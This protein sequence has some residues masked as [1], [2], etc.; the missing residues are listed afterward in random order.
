ML[1]AHQIIQVL[2]VSV[3]RTRIRVISN[4]VMVYER[5]TRWPTEYCAFV[6]T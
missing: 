4:G 3:I 6:I 2:I 1:H 5:V